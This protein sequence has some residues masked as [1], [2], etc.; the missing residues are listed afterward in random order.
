[1]KIN[2]TKKQYALLIKM[3][4]LGDWM[5]NA[6]KVEDERNKEVDELHSYILSFAKEYGME[7]M[8][9]K[10]EGGFFPSGAMDE[11]ELVEESRENYNGEIFWE[12]LIDRLAERDF[13]RKY[14]GKEIQAM[15]DW[16]ERAGH[17]DEFTEK[18]A[19]EFEENGLNRLEISNDVII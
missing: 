8:A 3:L 11:D 9:D 5:I 14:S 7:N 10:N 17:K 1:M 13:R 19:E 15:K 18:Y 6:I 2:L 16:I 4:Y 12:E